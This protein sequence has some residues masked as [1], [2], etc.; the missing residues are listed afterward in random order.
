MG[1]H[2]ARGVLGRDLVARVQQRLVTLL[3]SS[4]L[5]PVQRA[6]AGS[7]LGSLGDPRFR[8][9]AWSLPA[10]PLLGWVEIPA[11]PF[12]MGSDPGQD[13]EAYENEQP[14]HEVVL[15]AYYLARYPVTV[16]QWRAFVQA[17]GHTPRD[18]D[19]LQGLAN[20]PVMWVSWHDALA[21]CDWLTARLREWSGTP[22]PLAYLLRHE[23]W[24]VTLPSEAEWE[25][26]ARGADGRR[27]PWGEAPD[28]NR[29]NY[30]DTQ[31]GGTSPVGCFPGGASPYGLEDMSGNVWE[32]TRSIWGPSYDKMTFA[33]P[34][35]SDDGREQ[36]Q[37]AD[38]MS[39]VLRGGAF[40]LDRQDVRC[41]RRN[42][43]VARFVD[44]NIG[45]RVALAG[46]P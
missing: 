15:P 6:A 14:Q 20:H 42:W 2:R 12:R 44:L 22:E 1:P 33:Y 9:E 24:A 36:L 43:S 16:A 21:Y 34:Y 3:R 25:K 4:A 7:T 13:A 37:A 5:P 17:S 41:A 38:D 31:I 8:A 11:G 10:E 19:S 30:N 32:W 45:F 35:R 29:A 23:G 40:W 28:P 26:A 27:Y 39:R 46:P 18:A